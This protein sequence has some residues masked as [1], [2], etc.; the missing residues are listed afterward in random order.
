MAP[1]VQQNEN[2]DQ[3]ASSQTKKSDS[4]IVRENEEKFRSCPPEKEMDKILDDLPPFTYNTIVKYVRNS[5]KNIQN[6]PHY[7]VMKP[8][9]RGV[10]FFIEGYLHNVLVKLHEGSK[11]F[12]IRAL[13]YRSL[14]KNES[15]HKIRIAISTEQ[16]YDVLASSCTCVAGS[17][18][19]C[20]HAVGLMYL[21]S[22]YY[23]T[24]TKSI[25]DDL[26]C[27]S[28]PQQWHKPRGKSISSEPLMGMVFKK[29]KLEMSGGGSTSGQTSPGISC[30]LYPAAKQAPSNTE[31]E[32][33]KA[34]LQKLNKNFGLSLYMNTES[35][36]VPTRVGPAP[37]GGYLSYQLAPTE[38]NF[39]VA[40]NVD[41]SKQRTSDSVPITIYPSLPL[42]LVFPLF[43]VTQCPSEHQQFY[44]SLRISEH[45]AAS[46]EFETQA[47]RNSS[48]WWSERRSRLTASTFGDIL[49][50]RSISNSFLK[51]LV[52]DMDTSGSL[53][54][55]PE[56]LKHGIEHESKALEQYQNYLKHSGHPV[57]TLSSGFVV[58]PAYPFLGCS[59]DAKVIDETEDN[60][61]GIA[62]IK[63]PY[64]HRNVTPE[65]ACTGDSQFHLQMKD[66]FPALKT[67]HKYYYQVHG[68]MG[69]TGAKWCDFVTYT[70]Q[71]MII[72]RIYF[73][74]NFFA[75]MLLKLEQFFFKHFVKFFKAL[76]V[77]AGLCAV[78]TTS[79]V[80]VMATSASSVSG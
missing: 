21:V 2:D 42:S 7:M 67:N 68:Q 18:G 56:P 37:L 38:G 59:P 48:R 36:N 8:F 66:G 28:L 3:A 51:G 4:E 73:D 46:L 47:Q 17:L 75:T 20:N 34:H 43:N 6:S 58:N 45:D 52:K 31:I 53:R 39:K 9:E 78:P 23:L 54:N 22:H 27:T 33:F 55:L 19:F 25:P 1:G 61:F 44:D 32:G 26:V 74:P 40:C 62:E 15:P 49:S 35:K 65:T 11:T 71:G 63:C 16:P 77:P 64:K 12:Y 50:R 72:E 29:P 30:S 24:K 79:T 57:K 41:L 10:N 76:P 13:C 69:I 60:P 14:R 5:G 80:T 70:F